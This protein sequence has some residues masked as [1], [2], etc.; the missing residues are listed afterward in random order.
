MGAKGQRDELIARVRS[1]LEEGVGTGATVVAGVSGGADSVAL[2]RL[3]VAARP[4]LRVVVGHVR[5]GLRDDAPDAA[6]ARAAATA[7]GAEWVEIR[8]DAANGPGAGPEDRARRARLDALTGLAADVGADAVLLGHTADDQAET[9][10]LRIARG[11]GLGG[12]AGMRARSHR[13][14][15][16]LLRPLLGLRRAAVRSLLADDEFVTDPTNADPDQRRARARREVLPALGRLRPDGG[17]AVPALA[18]LAGLAAAESDLLDHLLREW[19]P[20][21]F[22]MAVVVGDPALDG[23]PPPVQDALVARL[24]RWGWQLLP[25]DSRPPTA[26]TIAA[27]STL[28]V[29]GRADVAGGVGADR[30]EAAWVLVSAGHPRLPE[31]VLRPSEPVHVP[32]HPLAYRVDGPAPDAAGGRFVVGSRPDG[33]PERVKALLRRHPVP[34]RDHVPVVRAADGTVVMV[35]VT[36]VRDAASGRDLPVRATGSLGHVYPESP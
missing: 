4:D 25:G 14:G 9:V 21:R 19:R 27:V 26:A 7:A 34:L 2:L 5:H 30:L 28:P 23:A 31:T 17:D 33:A 13:A 18:R 6:S 1:A 16:V 10:L 35:G 24:L 20:R 36:P 22:G 11:T 32:G 3:V 8:V 12:L 29:G 15:V